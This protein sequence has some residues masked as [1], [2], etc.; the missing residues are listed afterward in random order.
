MQKAWEQIKHLGNI[1]TQSLTIRH[2]NQTAILSSLLGGG[3]GHRRDTSCGGRAAWSPLEGSPC[4]AGAWPRSR[5]WPWLRPSC[6]W[7]PSAITTLTAGTEASE[8]HDG[9]DAHWPRF[10]LK[11]L[12]E[13]ISSTSQLY[14][15]GK[16]LRTTGSSLGHLEFLQFS[17]RVSLAHPTGALYINQSL[18]FD[19]LNWPDFCW[20]P[21]RFS[22]VPRWAFN[23]TM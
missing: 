22:R 12:H 15:H 4:P 9:V 13:V 6:H 14:P 5:G 17:W 11:P 7:T 18:Q 21:V 2:K 3:G 19:T 1:T 10:L 8:G 23:L 20:L 16:D